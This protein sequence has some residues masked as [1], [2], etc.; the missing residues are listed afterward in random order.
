VE[1]IN[2]K[3]ICNVVNLP[4]L[5]FKPQIIH[6]PSPPKLPPPLPDPPPL[7]PGSEPSVTSP[8]LSVPGPEPSVP[9]P[10]P[11]VPDPQPSVTGPQPSVLGSE[12]SVPGSE[13]SVRGYG[14]SVTGQ[15]PAI[16]ANFASKTAF[17]RQ[18]PPFPPPETAFLTRLAEF[19]SPAGRCAGWWRAPRASGCGKRCAGVRVQTLRPQQ[20]LCFAGVS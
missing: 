5:K 15:E 11:S 8:P 1:R 16:F 13:P 4:R 19:T 14:S 7:L 18:S 10:E 3:S 17:F 6:D 9:G 20:P 12:P 2:P